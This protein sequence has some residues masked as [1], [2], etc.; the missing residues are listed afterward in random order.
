MMT[1]VSNI[2]VVITCYSEGQL[3]WNAIHSIRQQSFPALEI[4][5][6]NDAST[7]PDTINVCHQLEIQSDVQV[8]W[9]QENGGPSAARNDGFKAAQGAI[10]V[11]LDGDDLLPKQ[12]LAAI[13]QAFQEQPEAG[14]IYGTYLRQDRADSEAIV[15][16]PGDVSLPTMLRSKPFSLSSNWKLIGTTPLRKSLWEAIG[17]YDTEFGVDDLHDVEFW[18]RAIATGCGYR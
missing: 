3:L 15:V 7:H 18:I 5:V 13:H 9:R 6:V 4:I 1:V 8:I 10:L 11:P 17:G 12:A 16:H 2:S 14:F